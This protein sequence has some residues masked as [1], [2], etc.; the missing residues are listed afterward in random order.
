[1]EIMIKIIPIVLYFIVGVISL[2]MGRKSL[3]SKGFI[4]FHEEAAGMSLG[5]LDQRVQNVILALMKTTGL[6]FL[7]V[8]MLLLVFPVIGYFKSDIIVTFGIPI[9]C[10]IYCLGLFLANYQLH[11]KSGVATPWKGSLIVMVI[12]LVGIILSII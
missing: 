4:F 10:C 2:V 7:V 3:F 8:G 1:M 6:G 11:K 12:I 9:V 5:K